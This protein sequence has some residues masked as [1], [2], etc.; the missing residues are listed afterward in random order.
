MSNTPSNRYPYQ[1]PD[2]KTDLG[3]R[4]LFN[5]SA[6]LNQAIVTL[7][8]KVASVQTQVTTVNNTVTSQTTTTNTTTSDLPVNVTQQTADYVLQQTDAGGLVVFTGT[9][10]Y[11]LTLNVAVAKPFF[12]ACLNLSSGNITAAPT[13][14]S[15]RLV[16]NLASVTVLTTQW[17]I[18]YWDGVNWWALD[19]QVWPQTKTATPTE[20]LVSYDAT[21]G[22]FTA[23]QP[24]V[25]DIGW[26]GGA[27]GSRPGSPVNYQPYFD[28]TLGK[29]IW[30][31]S[32]QWVDATGTPV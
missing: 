4:L 1:H 30:W 21:T 17:A 7:T 13:S 31:D 25:S 20:F 11:N 26:A 16:N 29:P 28:T 14:G 15:S 12:C 18:F 9:G 10:P 5:S 2:P 8:E 6:D 27:T 23:A 32:T 22:L 3:F 19:L 24:Q